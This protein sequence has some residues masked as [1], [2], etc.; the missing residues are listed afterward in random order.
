[1]EPLKQMKYSY[2]GYNKKIQRCH[3]NDNWKVKAYPIL[4]KAT[5]TRLTRLY[6]LWL[7]TNLSRETSTGPVFNS[8]ISIQ[9]ILDPGGG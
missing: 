9:G 7:D 2:H 1:M 8:R 5:D 4:G 6:F 3:V